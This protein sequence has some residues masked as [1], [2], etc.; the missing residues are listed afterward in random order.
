MRPHG[1]RRLWK[2]A[3]GVGK[4]VPMDTGFPRQDTAAAPAMKH[5]T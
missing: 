1:E 3:V 5:A 2:Q 4:T